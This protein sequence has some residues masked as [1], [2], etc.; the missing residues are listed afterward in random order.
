MGI[1]K[2][3]TP[4]TRSDL[5]GGWGGGSMTARKELVETPARRPSDE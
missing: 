4:E 1:H 3:P 2:A 5:G